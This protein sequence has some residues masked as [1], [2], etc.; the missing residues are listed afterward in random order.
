[1]KFPKDVQE[2]FEKMGRKGG[3][4]GGKSKSDAKLASSSANMQKAIAVTQANRKYPPCP[5]YSKI[6]DKRTGKPYRGH[7]F[8]K[9]SGKCACGLDYQLI[10][11]KTENESETKSILPKRIT[12]KYLKR[13]T[14]ESRIAYEEWDFSPTPENKIKLDA[15]QK[16]VD[17][18]LLQFQK[19]HDP[20]DSSVAQND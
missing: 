13:V 3:K 8:N 17:D 5:H 1:M 14:E 10:A 16:K 19:E 4:K 18:A 20:S 9:K 6:T 12:K 15:T 7:R 2:F 11:V